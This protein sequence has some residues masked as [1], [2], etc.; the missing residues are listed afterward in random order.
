MADS[1]S[2]LLATVGLSV[3]QHASQV[4]ASQLTAWWVPSSTASGGRTACKE[5]LP[6]PEAPTALPP[7]PP[8]PQRVVLSF[9]LRRKRLAAAVNEAAVAHSAVREPRTRAEKRRM[10]Q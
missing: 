2:P 4:P 3:V 5:V 8:A 6:A 1:L 9:R 7:E 10:L